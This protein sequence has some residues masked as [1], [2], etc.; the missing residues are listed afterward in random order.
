[1]KTR[2]N[3]R[4]AGIRET[5]RE[6]V[7]LIELLLAVSILSVLSI[8]VM[9]VLNVGIESWTTG[10]ALADESHNAEAVM[11]QV[12]MSLRSAF[13]PEATEPSYEYGFMHKDGGETPD[14][15]DVIS[16]VKVGNSLIGED[17]P[18]AGAAHRVEL[19]I[20]DEGGEPGLYVK[21]WQL[22]G[23]DEE[24]DPEEDVEPL[25]ISD[26]V[27]SFDCRMKDPEKKEAIGEPYEWLDEWT[28][29]NRIP[30][31][32]MISIAMKPQKD[33]EN[34]MEYT[35][36]V[37]IPM[38]AMSWNP[39]QTR[40]SPRRPGGR[41]SPEGVNGP[42]GGGIRAPDGS[43]GGGGVTITPERTSGSR[44]NRRRDRNRRPERRSGGGDGTHNR[45]MRIRF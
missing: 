6:G 29:S 1:M 36:L 32:V 14:A 26:Q 4:F 42:G 35:R 17:T 8:T 41:N 23:Q 10:T 11:E 37:E 5:A 22:V 12:V 38:A 3:T 27:I 30:T 7:T 19:F 44:I 45:P 9:A 24:F 31:H 21:A 16:W 40:G 34:P 2:M 20:G 33:K 43:T 25:L 39:V 18:W 13:Y 15:E 28:P